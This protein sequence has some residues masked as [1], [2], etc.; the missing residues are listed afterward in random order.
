MSGTRELG[1]LNQLLV[2]GR[3]SEAV[4][5]RSLDG[6]GAVLETVHAGRTRTVPARLMVKPAGYFGLA[7][8]GGHGIVAPLAADAV[9]LRLTVTLA[10]GR[11]LAVELVVTG[12]D[13]ARGE[14]P[15][16]V[17][18]QTLSG[19]AVSGAPF[20]MDAVFDPKPVT[21]FGT[22]IADNDP[23]QPVDAADVVAGELSATTDGRGQFRL[24]P[25]PLQDSVTLTISKGTVSADFPF[26]PDFDTTANVAAFSLDL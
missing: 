8:A 11:S 1:L 14:M 10:D 12:A 9:T 18:G 7:L 4:T 13:L 24:G 22:V 17:S 2:K 20:A 15:V 25:L 26:R 23:A 16:T 6:F 19:T 21:L 3:V 5:G